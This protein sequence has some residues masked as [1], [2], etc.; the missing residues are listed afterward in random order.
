MPLPV[1][2]SIEARGVVRPA[3]ATSVV[4]LELGAEMASWR[5]RELLRDMPLGVCGRKSKPVLALGEE[6]GVVVSGNTSPCADAVCDIDT[7]H[8]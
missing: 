1:L 5:R 4:R 2:P 8:T 3:G 7:F 6:T